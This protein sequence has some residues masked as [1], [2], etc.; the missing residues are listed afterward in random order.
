MGQSGAYVEIVPPGRLVF[1]ELFDDQSYPGETLITHEF[2]E[3]AGGTRLTS[4]VRY[5]TP[6]GRDTALRYPMRRGVAE[7]F[8]RLAAVLRSAP[9]ATPSLSNEERGDRI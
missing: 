2:A 6:E 9:A 4:T 5:A 3:Q 1:T 7:S 8:D